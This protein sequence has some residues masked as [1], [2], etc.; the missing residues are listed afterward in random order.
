MSFCNGRA[1]AAIAAERH[2]SVSPCAIATLVVCVWSLSACTSSLVLGTAYNAAATRTADRVKT[3]ADFDAAQQQWIEQSFKSF[4]QWHRTNELPTYSA[5][6]NEFAAT[7]KSDDPVATQQL[8]TWFKQIEE[9]TTRARSCSPLMGAAGFLT[10]MA[11]WQVEQ[12]HET[13]KSNRLKQYKKYKSESTEERRERRREL[14]ITWSSR[15]GIKLT[16]EQKQLLD[17]TLARQTSMGDQR[18][19]LWE[20]WTNDFISLL[21]QRD[22]AQFAD[23][24]QSHVDSLWTM[25]EE[26]YP[27][28]WR[29]NRDLWQGFAHAL[30]NDLSAEQK[31]SLAN[32]VAS[33]SESTLTLSRKKSRAEPVCYSG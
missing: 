26:K 19:Q 33:I 23:Q 28:E 8:D 12:L 4:Q 17:S 16:D 10:D 11:D 32:T 24:L 20:E 6:L 25:T 30:L 5:L 18:F 9:R 1:K 14:L 3:Y 29:Q 31:N 21:E 15:A 13:L 27:Q 2:R 7:L 22:S